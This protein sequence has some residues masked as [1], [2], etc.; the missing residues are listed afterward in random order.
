M[1]VL[2]DEFNYYE[3]LEIS[4]SADE[5]DIRRAYEKIKNVYS[6]DSLAAYGLYSAEELK[7]FRE[8]IEKAF[9]ML[10]DAENRKEYD[11]TLLS[12]PIRKNKSVKYKVR[13]A[14]SKMPEASSAS[15]DGNGD[16][17]KT[18]RAEDAA[19]IS[20][21]DRKTREKTELALKRKS[22]SVPED[23]DF[24]GPY[25]KELRQAAG[26]DLKLVSKTTKVSMTNLRFIEIEDWKKL[27]ALVYVKGFISQYARFLGLDEKKVLAEMVERYTTALKDHFEL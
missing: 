16:K 23:A 13:F 15:E 10:I 27:P 21:E 20:G 12:E 19:S 22:I 5:E 11:Q 7:D 18:K 3:L 26:I 1:S 17:E 2:K 24:S 9:R 14:D 6:S 25:L 4:M 8:Q